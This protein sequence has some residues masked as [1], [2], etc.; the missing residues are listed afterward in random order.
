M[1]TYNGKKILIIVENLPVPFDRRVWQEAQALKERGAKV[2]I[3]CPTS[4]EYTKRREVI[5]GVEI[6]R[7]KLIKEAGTRWEYLL[8]YVSALM[9][10]FF[11]SW[12]IFFKHGIDII[13]A[14]NPPDLIFLVALP[15]KLLGIKFVFDHHDIN[16]EL[17][18]AKYN[19]KGILF[20][21]ILSLEKFTFKFAD[22]SIATNESY[23]AIAIK[24]G[25]MSPEKVFVVRSG[26]DLNRLKMSASV[27]EHKKGRKY[28]VGYVGVIGKQEGLRYLIDAIYHMVYE[29]NRRDTHFV[30]IGSGPD[31]KNVVRYAKSKKVTEYIT[32][33]GRIPD[34][35]LISILN[36]SDVCVNPDEYNEMN[37]KSTM[38]KIMEYMAL[39]KPI[40]QF[41]LKEGKATAQD[42]SLYAKPND[43]VDMAENIMKLLDDPE[44]RLEMGQY[45]YER[46]KNKLSWDNEKWKLYKLYDEVFR[47]DIEKVKIK[48][49]CMFVHEYYPKDF[50][51][52]REAEALY[53]RGYK[54]DVI[55]L[56]QKGEK[57]KSIWNGIM[58]HRLPVRRHRGHPIYIY[59]FEYLSF[60]IM[61][62]I[63][64]MQ[65]YI[66]KRYDIVHVHNP[67]D[68]LVFAGAIIKGFGTKVIF[69]IHDRVPILFMSRF[70]AKKNRIIMDLLNFSERI[71][72]DFADKLIVSV[73]IYK[74]MLVEKGIPEEKIHV[75][76][77]SADERYFNIRKQKDVA[78]DKKLRLLYHGTLVSR[79]G[80]DTLI[81]A[82]RILREKEVDF[83]LDIYGS[84][85]AERFF[86]N[87]I[88][89]YK[90]EDRVFLRGF[91]LIDY[92]PD[93][94]SRADLCIVPNKKDTF[95][96]TVLPTK[97]LEYIVMEKPVVISRTKG[98]MEF[99]SENEVTFYNPG[100]VKELAEKILGF[101]DDPETYIKKVARAKEKYKNICFEKQKDNLFEIYNRI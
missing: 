97:L 26:P 25:K 1:S 6:Y 87:L 37:D 24:R 61:G 50:R 86:E 48:N 68:F 11:L 79:Y 75:I 95:M 60:F 101:N 35:E 9:G 66:K 80:V 46:V 2:F 93:F 45:G 8:E 49:V 84:G 14:C 3:I 18:L 85:D 16:P 53:G 78:D 64:L 12:W 33:T 51:V 42:A 7:H 52:R 89:K 70:G 29:K 40:V 57:S 76:L 44:K 34:E 17:F 13:H 32:F 73:N 36:T 94:I 43:S 21:L 92:M 72:I 99:F 47:E 98:A 56:R 91:Y 20:K 74:K 55:C 4:K 88:I 90:L 63:K 69:D 81:E 15:F 19:K 54:V 27:E 58:I 39:G 38:N 5:D 30:C 10:E 65:L 28:L 31:F 96:D 77:N 22:Y 100:S 71:S 23:K 67:P 59:I 82:T 41:D 83:T 62:M